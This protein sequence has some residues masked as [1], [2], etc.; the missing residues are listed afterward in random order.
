MKKLKKGP[1]GYSAPESTVKAYNELLMKTA[2]KMVPDVLS[3]NFSRKES[4]M[5]LMKNIELLNSNQ[6]SIIPAVGM[7]CTT[8][9]G[10]DCYPHTIV[11]VAEDLSYICTTADSHETTEKHDYYGNQDYTY[12]TNWNASRTLWTLRKDGAYHRD[13]AGMRLSGIA[14]GHRRYYQDPSF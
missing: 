1:W 10:S 12:T 7:G 9:F 13:G 11:A 14:V 4:L 2:K 5:K 8:G 3:R 6:Y